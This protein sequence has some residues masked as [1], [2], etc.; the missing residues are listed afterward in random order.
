MSLSA[1][2]ARGLDLSGDLIGGELVNDAVAAEHLVG[3]S[4]ADAEGGRPV[5][6]IGSTVATN[7]FPRESPLGKRITIGQRPFE[8]IGVTQPKGVDTNGLD[9]DDVILV[10]LGGGY[11]AADERDLRPDDLR[12]GETGRPAR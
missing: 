1:E 5:C 8:V 7:L 10:P 11:A 2:T 9:Q 3:L 12:P 4:A 6:V